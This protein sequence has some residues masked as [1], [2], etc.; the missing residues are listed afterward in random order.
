MN[1]PYTLAKVKTSKLLRG[2]V[3]TMLGSGT[4]KV[5]LMLATFL[6]A[7]TL[8]KNDFGEFSFVRNTLNTILCMCALNFTSLCT[9]F[10]VESKENDDAVKRLFWLFVFSVVICTITGTFLLFA[11]DN[12]LLN[13]FTTHTIIDSFRIIGLL[14]PVFIL[15]PLIEGIL[16]GLM[17]FKLIGI[18]QTASAIFFVGAVYAGIKLNGVVGALLGIITYYL[19]Y[20]IV[21]IIVITIIKPIP[22]F[23]NRAKGAGKEK[24]VLSKMILPI[25][26]MSFFEAPVLWIAQVLLA[27]YES[28]ESVGSMTAIM[29]IKNLT[30]LIPTYFVGTFLAFASEMN[31]KKQFGAYF[32]KFRQF[33][34]LFTLV[35]VV[36]F[37]MFSAFSKPLLGLY[38]ESYVNDWP[39]M[40]VSNIGIPVIM[41]ICLY[42]IDLVIREHQSLLLYISVVWNL[43]WLGSLYMLLESGVVPLMAFFV[44]QLVGWLSNLLLF[45]IVYK[46]DKRELLN[47][48][49]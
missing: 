22:D 30:I 3:A 19:L 12:I 27:R 16:R 13:I 11:P 28:M 41:L 36:L 33:G 6:F 46:R 14:L 8:S 35:G 42:R 31:A 47:A 29:Q 20:A 5:I 2:F 49:L 7:N 21:C 1:I 4:S 17:K 43:L 39:A 9:K 15:Q 48:K 26:L 37:I 23:Y 45:F 25:F 38:G 34:L 18:L 40:I 24:N 10:T 44:S 32:N